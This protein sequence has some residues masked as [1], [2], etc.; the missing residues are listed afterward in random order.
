MGVYF[1]YK[2]D[3]FLNEKNIS[4]DASIYYKLKLFEDNDFVISIQPKIL[5]SKSK[6]LKEDFLGEISLLM[7]MSKNIHSV[8]IFNQN[9]FSFGHS[10]NNLDSKK[11]YYNFSTCEG[12]KFKN[13]IMLTSFTKYHTKQNYGYVYDSSVYE[14]LGI[15]KIINFGEEN[16]NSLTAQ[17]GYFWDY[18]LSNK[19]YKISGISFSAWL[20]V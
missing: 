17:I 1:L 9:V 4:T 11:M 8:T 10:I 7:G 5:M 15:A 16:R 14:Q 20:D 6:K 2:E 12:I 19:K 3:K 13:G 18:S